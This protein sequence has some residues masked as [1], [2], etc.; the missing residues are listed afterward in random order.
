MSSLVAL[1]DIYRNF[2]RRLRTARKARHMSQEALA[3]RLRPRL[4]R[5]SITNIEAGSQHVPLH[6]LYELAAAVGV[7]A[8]SL[9]PDE[10][11]IAAAKQL[12]GL[13]DLAPEDRESVARAVLPHLEVGRR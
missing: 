1:D 12:S 6:M 4:S 7:R 13:E 9:L 11:T 10:P 3:A 8:Q 2:G 5:T